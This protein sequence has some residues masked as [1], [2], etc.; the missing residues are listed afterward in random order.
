MHTCRFC[1]LVACVPRALALCALSLQ[2]TSC[3]WL[4]LSPAPPTG[5]Q[6]QARPAPH[7]RLLPY[8]PARLDGSNSSKIPIESNLYEL[9]WLRR[10][11]SSRVG[12]DDR[13]R[14]RTTFERQLCESLGGVVG[15]GIRS[16]GS[17]V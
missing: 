8:F 10:T 12:L 5:D 4:S 7:L 1:A 6:L 17:A 9:A 13:L 14:P 3:A 11:W 16:P 15:L 2:S